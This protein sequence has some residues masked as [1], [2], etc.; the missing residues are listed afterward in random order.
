MLGRIAVAAFEE[1]WKEN[2][3]P[4]LFA[5]GKYNIYGNASTGSKSDKSIL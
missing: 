4:G 2:I 3:V 5:E 1:M